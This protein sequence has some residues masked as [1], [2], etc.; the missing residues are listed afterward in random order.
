MRTF[1]YRFANDPSDNDDV[2]LAKLT[3]LIVSGS[4]CIAGLLWALMYFLIYGPGLVSALPFSFVIIV[5]SF[6]FISHK[7][8][9]HLWAVYAQIVCIIYITAFIQ[10]S[11]GGV[12]DSG[13]VMAWAFCGPIAAL[14]FFTI[15]QATIWWIL[16]FINI[17]ITV[18]F[19]DH[20]SQGKLETPEQ[21]KILYFIMNI[22]VS[23]LTVFI[24]ASYFVTNVRK[25]KIRANNLL[26]NILPSGIA[27]RLKM[28]NEAIADNFVDVSV[29]FS[30]IVGFTAYS[31]KTSPE[32]L[33]QKLDAIFN[34][35]DI[36]AKKHNLE[37]IKTIGDAYMVAGG[38][39]HENKNHRINMA[40]MAID[41]QQAL[42]HLEK[43]TDSNFTIR[44]GIHSGPVVAGV[45]GKSKFAYDLWGDTVNVASRME[46]TGIPGK[47]QVSFDFM[48]GL[49]S[50]FLFEERGE[51]EAKGKG[52]IHTYFLIGRL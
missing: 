29:L 44:I 42:Y 33:V 22:G 3:A 16:F 15:R 35:F 39:P 31:G 50:Y 45:I 13:F 41:M 24:F 52:K 40:N 30:D 46:S 36:L 17:I 11:I 49:E 10:W 37:K 5:G 32:A 47:I 19:N 27:D 1:L 20:F 12:F 18:V 9:N 21:I 23:S 14:T 7:T 26:L 34:E 28:K 43:D 8:K 48:K 2:K 6:I 51:I 4:C 38:I 25:E